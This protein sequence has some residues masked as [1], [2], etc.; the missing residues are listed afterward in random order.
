M[1]GE[2]SPN[3]TGAMTPGELAAAVAR[4]ADGETEAWGEIYRAYAPA[5][6]R[7]CRRVLTRREDAE[8]ATTEIFLK[9]RMKLPQYD[10]SR[11]FEPWMYR[12][13]VN[14]CWDRL[15]R[16][17]ARRDREVD[18]AAGVPQ[19]AT[20]PEQL[21]RLVR[22]SARAALRSRLSR[23]PDRMRLALVARYYL[24]LSYR[25][26]GES[27]GLDPGAVGVLLLRARQR[28]RRLLDGGPE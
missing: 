1:D 18:D 28:L 11:P 26:I 19:A 15:R 3:R 27:M 8:D 9:L 25:E 2:V 21:E 23:L 6:F 22:A 4:V 5:V 17:R 24:D 10:P 20:D 14:H 7:L 12:L 13:A 16:G